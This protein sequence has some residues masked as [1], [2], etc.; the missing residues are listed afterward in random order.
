MPANAPSTIGT[1]G[2]AD[3]PL[4]TVDSYNVEIKDDEGFIGDKASK[5]AF[6]ELV[7]E[8]R[9]KLRDLG[10]DPLGD[11]PTEEISKRTFDKLLAEGEPEAVGVIQGAAEA[12]SQRLA[13]VLKRFK[14]LKAW[15][16]VERVVVGGGFR[17][18]RL[19]ELVIGRASVLLKEEK[20][21][22]GAAADPP[23][24]RRG[25]TGRLHPPRAELDVLRTQQHRRGRY[26]RLEHPLRHR[27]ARPPE[28][29]ATCRRQECGS[30][31]FGDMPT[32]S[33]IGKKRSAVSI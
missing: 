21:D 17:D 6:L 31:S 25:R 23:P 4:V 11:K 22:I 7:E 32:M 20:I 5:G 10:D 1:H 26:R 15:K 8:I 33:P 13:Q 9:G 2:S 12:F 3:L 18:S 19:G 28:E 16:G 30:P 24:S 29:G 14:R 27:R